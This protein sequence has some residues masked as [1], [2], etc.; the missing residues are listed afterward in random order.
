M[1]LQQALTLLAPGQYTISHDTWEIQLGF[2]TIRPV[3]Y[4]GGEDQVIFYDPEQGLRIP[5]QDQW[6]ATA[7]NWVRRTL[8]A[9]EQ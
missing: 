4:M 5:V 7:I 3:L 1:D 6:P 2:D 9:L 8:R